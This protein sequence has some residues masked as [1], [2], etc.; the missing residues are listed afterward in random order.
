MKTP[1][2]VLLV[3]DEEVF[4]EMTSLKLHNAGYDTVTA[5]GALEAMKRLEEL[6]PDLL[7]SDIYMPP[8]PN[9]LELGL[10]LRKNP[11]TQNIKIAFLSSLR[12]PGWSFRKTSAPRRCFSCEMPFSLIKTWTSNRWMNR[13]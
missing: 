13:F 2:L 10:A 7:L 12:D 5:N 4:L 9:G 6:V 1:P 11:K 8:G 3:D